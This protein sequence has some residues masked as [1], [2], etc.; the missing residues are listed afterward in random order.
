[1]VK[2]QKRQEDRSSVSDRRR[3]EDDRRRRP[4]QGPERRLGDRRESHRVPVQVEI[5]QGNGPF[6]PHPGN[7][8]I[9]GVFFTKPLELPTGAVVQLRFRLPG[10]ERTL[11]LKGEVVEVSLVSRP[12]ERGTRVRFLEPDIQTE[13]SIARFL[14][15]NPV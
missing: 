6:E 14:D 2:K 12:E 11:Q 13:L 8:G 7:I 4:Q 9:G 3:S 15:E 10:V 5:R 1:M